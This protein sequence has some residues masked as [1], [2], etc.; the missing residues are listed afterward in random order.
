M[1]TSFSL[2]H[3]KRDPDIHSV[4]CSRLP[5]IHHTQRS[6]PC[7]TLRRPELINMYPMPCNL[8]PPACPRNHTKLPMETVNTE[9]LCMYVLSKLPPPS[10][11][12]NQSAIPN[13]K[14][15]CKEKIIICRGRKTEIRQNAESSNFSPRIPTKGFYYSTTHPLVVVYTTTL[16][17]FQHGPMGEK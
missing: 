10:P 14:T 2:I 3:T 4:I 15:L 5:S 11:R 8:Q 17:E 12:T 7:L 13:S 6:L 9:L 16:D 1:V